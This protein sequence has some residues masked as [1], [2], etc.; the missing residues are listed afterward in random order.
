MKTRQDTRFTDR[1]GKVEAL[2]S[3]CSK[4]LKEKLAKEIEKGR[5]YQVTELPQSLKEKLRGGIPF[6]ARR[7][8]F[9]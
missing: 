4:D 2:L 1:L 8:Q 3:D 5:I 9:R 7:F 6:L